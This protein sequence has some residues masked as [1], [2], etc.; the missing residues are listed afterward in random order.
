MSSADTKRGLASHVKR[1]NDQNFACADFAAAFN[2]LPEKYP[3][4]WFVKT[5][6]CLIMSMKR[7]LV[8]G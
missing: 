7:A 2:K 6:G 3:L 1:C 4:S 5:G 8:F